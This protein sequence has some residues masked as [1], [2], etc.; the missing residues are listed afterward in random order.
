MLWTLGRRLNAIFEISLHFFYLSLIYLDPKPWNTD[1][2]IV[3]SFPPWLIG[4]WARAKTADLARHAAHHISDVGHRTS[5]NARVCCVAGNWHTKPKLIMLVKWPAGNC[6]Q[7][8]NCKTDHACKTTCWQ[9]P[10]KSKLIMHVKQPAGNCPK[11]QN[12][13]CM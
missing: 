11:K 13:S 6:S 8:Q 10:T 4:C 7:N 5:G 1:L 12:W 9:L 3:E 2:Q